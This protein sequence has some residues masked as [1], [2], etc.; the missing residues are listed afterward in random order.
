MGCALTEP[1]SASFKGIRVRNANQHWIL[2]PQDST[3]T[4]LSELTHVPLN[5][6][7]A[8]TQECDFGVFAGIIKFW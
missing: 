6:H 3:C 1:R 7:P 4:P 2:G 8:R 5:S